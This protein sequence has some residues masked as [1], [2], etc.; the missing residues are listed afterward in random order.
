MYIFTH[1]ISWTLPMVVN[2]IVLHLRYQLNVT[3]GR[4]LY[5]IEPTVSDKLY[6]W[7]STEL[8]WT[9]CISSMLPMVFSCIVLNLMYQL[10]V[11]NGRQLYYF[12]PTLSVT[13]YQ[14]SSTVLFWTYCISSMLPVV[15][16]CIILNLL[17]QLNVTSGRQLYCIEPTV[18]VQLYQWSSTVLYWTYCIS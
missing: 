3:N 4:Q 18:S 9:Y 10:N 5:C 2:C 1:C 12:E 17:Y 16:N 13:C 15:V 11:N 8:Y 6:Q 14:L 7:S